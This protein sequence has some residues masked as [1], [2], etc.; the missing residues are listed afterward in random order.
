MKEEEA[1][2]KEREGGRR[3]GAKKR[4]VRL[5]DKRISQPIAGSNTI[6]ARR[7]ID[8]EKERRERRAETLD[9]QQKGWIGEGRD[10]GVEE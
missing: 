3:V 9:I 2:E 5:S 4:A 6:Q 10:R 7:G 8:Q 1:R